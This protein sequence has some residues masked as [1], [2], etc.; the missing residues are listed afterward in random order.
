M[1][2]VVKSVVVEERVVPPMKLLTVDRSITKRVTFYSLAAAGCSDAGTGMS[3][4]AAFISL[5][6]STVASAA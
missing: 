1:K 2:I 4:S 6:V 3:K 5:P